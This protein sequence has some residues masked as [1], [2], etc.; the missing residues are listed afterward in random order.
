MTEENSTDFKELP[1]QGAAII[2]NCPLSFEC[3]MQWESLTETMNLGVR[4]CEVCD[5][6]V[7]FCKD[8]DTLERL[9]Q[10]GACVAFYTRRER[11][12]VTLIGSIRSDDTGREVDSAKL[13]SFL[14]S[15]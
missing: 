15:L 11:K 1:T 10:A 13:R 7:T 6:Q 4:Y 5:R 14:D 8:V 12:I 9:R 3:P 2:E